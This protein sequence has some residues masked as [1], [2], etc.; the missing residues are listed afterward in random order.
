MEGALRA[1]GRRLAS[2]PKAVTPSPRGGAQEARSGVEGALRA[3]GRRL[4]SE[5]AVVI[6]F[7]LEEQGENALDGQEAQGMK[8]QYFGDIRDLFKYDLALHLL[9]S[10]K[11]LDRFLFIPM[12]TPDDDRSDGGK[13]A[14]QRA[15]AGTRNRELVEFLRSR[16]EQGRRDVLEITGYFTSRGVEMHMHGD[17]KAFFTQ[18]GRAEYFGSIDQR[19]LRS[20]LILL[21][22][23]IGLE[24][25]DADE[26]H[27]MYSEVKQ[28]CRRMG[29]NS[30]MMIF[31]YLPRENRPTYLYRRVMELKQLTGDQPEYISDN[32]IIFFFICKNPSLKE[33]LVAAL[34]EYVRLYPDLLIS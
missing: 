10:I 3:K 4:A 15:R 19:A 20:S 34:R 31:Q 14:Y 5:S 28:L 17:G 26:K 21:D 16:V 6:S 8:N 2:E 7:P 23:D 33:E 9:G 29:Y 12:L 30:L 18:R 24:V 1:K 32:E 27:L 13:T 11:R 22:P 25:R